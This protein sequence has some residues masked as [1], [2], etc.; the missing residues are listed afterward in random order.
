[1]NVVNVQKNSCDITFI[2]GSNTVIS[3]VAAV[4]VTL[5]LLSVVDVWKLELGLAPY[6][7]TVAVGALTLAV[8]S[9]WVALRSMQDTKYRN[10]ASFQHSRVY[11]KKDKNVT[12]I[13]SLPQYTQ[14][15]VSNYRLLQPIFAIT[16]YEQHTREINADEQFSPIV[17]IVDTATQQPL[18]CML[19]LCGEKPPEVNCRTLFYIAVQVICL[20]HQADLCESLQHPLYHVESKP[21]KKGKLPLMFCFY[22]SGMVCVIQLSVNSIADSEGVEYMHH[23]ENCTCVVQVL[24]QEHFESSYHSEKTQESTDSMGTFNPP[25]CIRVI[26]SNYQLLQTIFAIA[27]GECHTRELRPDEQ[28]SPIV[29]IAD[30]AT[31]QTLDCVLLLHGE[32]PP[33]VNYRTLFCYIAVQVTVVPYYGTHNSHPHTLYHMESKLC[34]NSKLQLIFCFYQPRTVWVIQLSVKSITD[35]KGV[36]FN[37]HHSEDCTCIVKVVDQEQHRCYHRGQ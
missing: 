18:D 22:Q 15:M 12:D 36:E 8:I 30:A 31:Q 20:S 28:F 7:I 2:L 6:F 19:L 3:C 24:D 16:E 26:V 14:V 17:T 5:L 32:K 25:Q 9:Y 23:S 1:M 11:P 13:F 35:S 33:E 37:K 10:L 4:G 27:K 29:T 34:E 21:C